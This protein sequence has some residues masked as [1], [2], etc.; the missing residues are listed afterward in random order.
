MNRLV[1]TLA[2]GLAALG[3]AHG[4]E[5]P[6][7][8]TQVE[9]TTRERVRSAPGTVESR[10]KA[11]ISAEVSGRVEA[12][13]FDVGDTVD[14]GATLVRLD[15]SDLR[16]RLEVAR[17]ALAAADARLQQARQDFNRTKRL[18]E[19]E[20]ASEQQM[21]Q[22]TAG[23]ERARAERSRAQAEIGRLRIRLDKTTI[24]APFSGVV[25]Q[26]HIETGELAQPGTPLITVLD[27]D[28]L[29]L[30]A[31]VQESRIPEIRADGKARAWIPALD[32]RLTAEHV[33][34]V[35]QGDPRTHTFEVRLHLP[36]EAGVAAGMFGRAELTLGTW[37][38]LLVPSRAIV[39]RSEITGVYVVEKD[40]V[41]FRLIELG[42]ETPD[43]WEVLAGLESGERIA[44]EPE[45][46]LR[47]LK[48]T[49]APASETGQS[50]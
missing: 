47:Y 19:Q 46:A 24:N 43:G 8:T 28:R 30:V 45:R 22:A 7:E 20:S 5:L 32:K 36:T 37:E 23:L 48:E 11:R 40:R 13:P 1:P 21:D 3:P 38:T 10:Q 44:L 9:Q 6:F 14:A 16:A 39:R 49:Q 15:D 27:P 34:V 35:P 50:H 31:R 26:R 18:Y 42:E 33:T 2:L 41:S 4:A 25:V 12:L 29:R 17:A